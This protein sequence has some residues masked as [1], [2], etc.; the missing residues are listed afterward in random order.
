MAATACERNL[1]RICQAK[2]LEAQMLIK[3]GKEKD[4]D[5]I[6]KQVLSDLEKSSWKGKPTEAMIARVRAMKKK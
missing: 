1:I 4:A 6:L 5:K 2:V 3:T